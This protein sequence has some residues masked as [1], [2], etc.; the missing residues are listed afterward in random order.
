VNYSGARLGETREW[1]VR[2]VLGLVH[3]TLSGA[4]LGSTLSCLAPNIAKSPTQ[5]L[6]LFVLNLMHLR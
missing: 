3:W 5:I 6:S 1:M 2:L 4:P